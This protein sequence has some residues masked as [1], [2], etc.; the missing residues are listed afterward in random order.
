[1]FNYSKYFHYFYNYTLRALTLFLKMLFV[2][3]LAKLVEPSVVGE[4]GLFMGYFNFFLMVVGFEFYTYAQRELINAPKKH[5]RSLLKAQVTTQLG[6]NLLFLFLY[7]TLHLFIDEGNNY[8]L[9]MLALLFTEQIAQESNRIL[10]ALSR[11]QLATSIF[12]IRSGLWCLIATILMLWDDKFKT[13]E[14]VFACWLTCSFI[15]SVISVYIINKEAKM[16]YKYVKFKIEWATKGLKVAGVF[17]VAGLAPKLL[18]FLDRL[19]INELSG[20][21]PLAIYVF[22]IGI[23]MAIQ[24]FL[25]SSVFAM[26][27]PKLIKLAG[28]NEIGEFESELKKLLLIVS[29]QLIIIST[30]VL[31]ILPYLLEWVDKTLYQ[32]NIFYFYPLLCMVIVYSLGMIPHYALYALK[33]EKFIFYCQA[34]GLLGFVLLVFILLYNDLLG[35]VNSVSF[36]LIF[37]FVIILISKFYYYWSNRNKSLIS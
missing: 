35:V 12:F 17:F 33:K 19:I 24:N 7:L 1:M 31:S 6:L 34:F 37:A 2:I 5:M 16:E 18:F 32:D 23:A 3:F 21:E 20:L 11:H 15:A 25:S 9:M 13:L 36:S 26:H 8:P 4:Y 22:F 30:V 28:N 10:I 27:Y 29:V 14:T